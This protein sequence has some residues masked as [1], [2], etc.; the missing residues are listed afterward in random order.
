LL[1]SALNYPGRHPDLVAREDAYLGGIYSLLKILAAKLVPE[2][3]SPP[4]IVPLTDSWLL[5]IHALH[6]L[7][8]H[9]LE[10]LSEEI[11]NQ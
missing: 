3:D 10:R 11:E 1:A 4:D 9:E 7:Q 2:A 6:T 8:L 5:D